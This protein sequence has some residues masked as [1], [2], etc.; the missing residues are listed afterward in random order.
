VGLPRLHCSRVRLGLVLTSALYLA[1]VNPVT[2]IAQ[3][4]PDGSPP[5]CRAPAVRAPAPAPN[6]IAVLPFANRSPDSAD[7]FLAEALP[8]QIQ[9]R[10]VRV[11][12]LQPKSQTAVTAQWRRT[13]DPIQA[14]RMLR[15]A[16]LVTGTV[17]RSG[18]S[19]TVAAEL[20]RASSGDG[21]WSATFRRDDDDLAAIEEQ[22]AESV[23][24][25]IVGR[26]LPAQA[27]ALRR[28]PTR[29]TEAYRLYLYGRTLTARRTPGEIDA[30]VRAFTRAVALDPGF[31]AAWGRL[32]YARSLQLDWGNAEG[33]S[34][35]SLRM[36]CRTAWSRALQL[37][38]SAVEAWLARGSWADAT[39][40]E[41]QARDALERALDLDSANAE[42]YHLLGFMHG[43]DRLDLPRVA[44]PLFARAVALD[45]DLRNS[46]RHLALARAHDGRLAEAEEAL[47][48]ALTR[49]AWPLGSNERAL[50]RFAR[51]NVAGALTDLAD[52]ERGERS[53]PRSGL[54]W[55][56][57]G[58]EEWR[59]LFRLGVGDSSGARAILASLETPERR[60][61]P[62]REVSLALVYTL[63]GLRDSALAALERIRAAP[64]AQ[65][66][67]CGPSP[68]S[69]H[70][71]LW[72]LLHEPIFAPLRG[73]PRF[74]RLWAETRP[75]VPWLEGYH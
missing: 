35:D 9:G 40:D 7:T 51:H 5:P 64:P 36:L 17:R 52:W 26:L 10:L 6:S 32:G 58:V 1:V 56:G 45:P 2:V 41:A 74:E 73:D 18:R 4:C 23:A 66:P 71:D 50:I 49:G 37:D 61:A 24:V 57:L 27:S 75:R 60:T 69:V 68:C 39:G 33:P 43:V 30:A 70:L 31:A 25:A 20:V 19:L 42:I 29:N 62:E 21:A 12:G 67:T 65:Q 55:R 13:P 22:V 38:S 54:T 59:A 63:L 46:W 47:D 16:W 15:T 11:S 44:M 14:A 34:D 8:E 3:Q 48:T 53:M 72:G 28:M